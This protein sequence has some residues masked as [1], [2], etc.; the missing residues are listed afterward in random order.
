MHAAP[1]PLDD[2]ARPQLKA[3]D[4]HQ[5]LGVDEFRGR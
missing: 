2:G 4:I 3:A 5:R 1:K